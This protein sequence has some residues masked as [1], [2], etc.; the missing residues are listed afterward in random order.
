MIRWRY[1]VCFTTCEI[2]VPEKGKLTATPP[3]LSRTTITTPGLPTHLWDRKDSVTRERRKPCLFESMLFF[4]S[5]TTWSAR[6]AHEAT[7]C[8]ATFLWRHH[9]LPKAFGSW[10]RAWRS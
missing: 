10:P 7:R 4:S 2:L 6:I 5:C 1:V 9:T 8:G 3:A